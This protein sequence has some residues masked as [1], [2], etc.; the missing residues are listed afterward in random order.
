VPLHEQ[1]SSFLHTLVLRGVLPPRS[2]LPSEPVLAEHLGV[3][4]GTLRRATATLIERQLLTQTHG[5]GTFVAEP[6]VEVEAPFVNEITSLAQS[7]SLRGVR[8]STR[9]LALDRRPADERAAAELGLRPGEPMIHLDRLRSDRAGPV[10]RLVNV[11][12]PDV[13]SLDD[14]ARLAEQGLYDLFES[15]GT[16]PGAALRTI[17]AT[18]AD[19]E[20]SRLLD[21]PVG[22]PLLHIEQRTTLADGRPLEFSDVWVRGERLKLQVRVQRTDP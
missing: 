22:H 20:L 19:D 7:L 1:L 18:V 15:T 10:M 6:A 2:Q 3:S 4:R 9:V 17:G 12:R 14:P 8:T 16:P 21:V 13:V 5:V 11:M